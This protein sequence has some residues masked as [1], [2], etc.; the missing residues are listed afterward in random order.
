MFIA[1]DKSMIIT[2]YVD[3]ILIFRDNNKNIKKIQDLLARQFK[4]TDLDKMSHYL[5]M[6]IDINDSKTSICQTNYLINVLN[7]F[8]FNDCKSCKISMNSSTVNHVEQFIKQTDKETIV[9][10]QLA[11]DSLI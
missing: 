3:D 9:Y 2:V 4:I 8:E 5:D 10:Y 6:E 1:V 11:V 7:H